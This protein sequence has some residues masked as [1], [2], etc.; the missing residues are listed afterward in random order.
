ME[1]FY[2]VVRTSLLPAQDAAANGVTSLP[3]TP[4]PSLTTSRR[5]KF[6]DHNQEI[7]IITQKGKLKNLVRGNC[8]VALLFFCSYGRRTIELKERPDTLVKNL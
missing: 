3:T 7:Q 2:Y 1:G 6:Y 4:P 8:F 5:E